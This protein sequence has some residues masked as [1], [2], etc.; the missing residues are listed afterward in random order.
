MANR[1]N[2]SFL[3]PNSAWIREQLANE[4]YSSA[5]DLINDLVRQARLAGERRRQALRDE[6]TKE[7]LASLASYRKTGEHATVEQ[8]FAELQLNS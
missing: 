3:E 2:I 5:S 8:V 6:L 1:Q 4:E 7:A